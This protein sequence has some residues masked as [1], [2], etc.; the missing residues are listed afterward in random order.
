M[1]RFLLGF[2]IIIAATGASELLFIAVGGFIGAGIMLSG[3]LALK[4][5]NY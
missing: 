1:I 2:L 3:A 4:E 5:E